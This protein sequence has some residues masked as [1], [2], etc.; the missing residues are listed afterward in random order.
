MA[1]G[2]LLF[3]ERVSKGCGETSD[4]QMSRK[5]LCIMHKKL[6]T[7]A[8]GVQEACSFVSPVTVLEHSDRYPSGTP[9]YSPLVSSPN[10]SATRSTTSR[11]AAC[12]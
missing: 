1:L 4:R 10:A 9:N 7:L 8:N 12:S 3:P 6:Y 5:H 11:R 2:A